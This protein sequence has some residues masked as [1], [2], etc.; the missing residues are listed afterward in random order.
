VAASGIVPTRGTRALRSLVAPGTVRQRI[1]G[2][3]CRLEAPLPRTAENTV[4]L[5]QL[6]RDD[7][8]GIEAHGGV[9]GE[10]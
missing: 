10:R 1:A 3:L 6:P 5:M 8:A 4:L 9:A 2:D 7:V